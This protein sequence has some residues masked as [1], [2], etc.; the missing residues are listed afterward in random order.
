MS[1]HVARLDTGVVN[2][3]LVGYDIKSDHD[4]LDRLPG[5]MEV[6]NAQEKV[7]QVKARS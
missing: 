2:G 5:Q 6:Y 3:Q 1:A 7:K 4:N